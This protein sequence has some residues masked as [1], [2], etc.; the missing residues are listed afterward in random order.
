M[1]D[2]RMHLCD[3]VFEEL[4]STYFSR[5]VEKPALSIGFLTI[6]GPV[7]DSLPHRQT[8][9][10]RF[11]RAMIESRGDAETQDLLQGL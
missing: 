4:L 11:R 8:F 1:L 5:C 7:R 10:E 6:S 3:A 2:G 9:L